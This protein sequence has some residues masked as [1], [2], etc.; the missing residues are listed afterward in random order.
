MSRYPNP[1]TAPHPSKRSAFRNECSGCGKPLRKGR[2]NKVGYLCSQCAP[3]FK[4]F[5]RSKE[6]ICSECSFEIE[7][8]E[9]VQLGIW[10]RCETPDIAD[11]ERLRAIGEIDSE[12]MR[13]ELDA[14][15]SGTG[16]RQMLEKAIS[17]GTQEIY[18]SYLEGKHERVTFPLQHFRE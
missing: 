1:T 6:N 4:P 2:R 11:I 17:Q 3:M 13:N 7:C 5:A 16:N 14:T 9:R 12:D 10:V 8:S 15:L 18:M